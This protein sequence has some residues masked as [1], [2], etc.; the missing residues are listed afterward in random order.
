MRKEGTFEGV[1]GEDVS[2]NGGL[3]WFLDTILKHKNSDEEAEGRKSV[4][5]CVCSYVSLYCD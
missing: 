2:D 1:G 5:L 4:C 3:F